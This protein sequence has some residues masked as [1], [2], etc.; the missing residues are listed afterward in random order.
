M[1]Q[2][3]RIVGLHISLGDVPKRAA[4]EADLEGHGSR[5]GGFDVHPD[6]LGENVTSVGL[7]GEALTAGWRMQMGEST[8]IELT[9]WRKPGGTLSVYSSA[10]AGRYAR[11]LRGGVVRSGDPIEMTLG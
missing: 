7:P 5:G 10:K 6:W 4:W 9:K 1:K 2:Q 11:V 8:E 3:G